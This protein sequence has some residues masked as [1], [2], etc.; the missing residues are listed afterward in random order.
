[1]YSEAVAYTPTV[2]NN[3]T[4]ERDAATQLLY[5]LRAVGP[6]LDT[7]ISGGSAAVTKKLSELDSS[8]GVQPAYQ[9]VQQKIHQS[10][11]LD[12]AFEMIDKVP[13]EMKESLY[14]QLASNFAARGDAA[15]ARQIINDKVSNPF[16]RRQAL[17]NVDLQ[18]IYQF[19]A[20]GKIDD[21]LRTINGFKTP[22]ERA[23]LLGQIARQIGPG[24]KRA[25]AVSFLEQAR[26][27]LSPG[28]QAQDQE[29]MNALLEL[30]RA[31]ARYDA[32][33]AFEIAEPLVD[34]TN[35]ICAAARTLEGFGPEYYQNDELDLQNG[36]SVANVVT[37]ISGALGT[38]AITNFERA[39]STADRL[40][41]P[42]V[43][44][45]A[46]LDIV[47]QTIQAK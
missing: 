19:M 42:E 38:L 10:G 46:Y 22:R 14:N 4:P 1:V 11:P 9:E 30:A 18:E 7:L 32:K 17:M 47:Q 15:R 2:P 27:M 44:L 6:E 24:Q 35:D 25:A 23:N 36:N 28:G 34:Q 21:A 26:A 12:G 43:R 13:D 16:H 8:A 39:K 5:G 20:R 3:Y 40:R 41:Q 31:F 37:Q 33:R 29:Q 45:R